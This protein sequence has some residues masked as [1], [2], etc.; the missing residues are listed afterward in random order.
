MSDPVLC[1]VMG[2][3]GVGKT[4]VGIAVAERLGVPFADADDLHSA[5]NVAKMA[6]GTP[7]EDED[8]WPW[9]AA[10]GD[11]LAAARAAGTG[12]VMACSALKRSYR[13]A[14]RARAGGVFFLHLTASEDTLVE[15]LASRQGHFMPPS[16]L[17]SQLE[18]LEPLHPDEAGA[19]VDASAG[20]DEV[21]SR[22]TKVLVS[23]GE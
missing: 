23:H 21:V 3:S 2:A 14:I 13:D 10:V 17:A 16:L 12:L 20:F 11:E 6:A 9:L 8:R 7:L 18:T 1:V 5:A 4:T 15:H 22:A 19:A